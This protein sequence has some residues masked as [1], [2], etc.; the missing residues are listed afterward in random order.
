V[1]GG[2]RWRRKR[3]SRRRGECPLLFHQAD[4]PSVAGRTTREAQGIERSE[5]IIKSRT[6]LQRLRGGTGPAD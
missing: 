5:D 1:I 3:P 6:P 2:A 4:V